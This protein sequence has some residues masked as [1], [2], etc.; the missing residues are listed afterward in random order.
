MTNTAPRYMIPL[1]ILGALVYFLFKVHEIL[2]PFVLG[3][4][5]AYLLSPLVEFFE[6]RGLRRRPVVVFVFGALLAAISAGTYVAL[7]LAAQEASMASREMPAYVARGQRI[8]DD[9]SL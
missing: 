7:N 1:A 2:L 3:A 4:T 9:L 6:V 8:Y 5:L